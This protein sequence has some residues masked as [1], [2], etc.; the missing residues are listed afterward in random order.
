MGAL[1]LYAFLVFAL[2]SVTVYV[3]L[4]KLRD[5]SGEEARLHGNW[6]RYYGEG[7]PMEMGSAVAGSG[8]ARTE[9]F[10]QFLKGL[11]VNK[12]SAETE[13]LYFVLQFLM[14]MES[15]MTIMSALQKTQA[16]IEGAGYK[17]A[18]DLRKINFKLQGGV[19]FGEAIKVLEGSE[20]GKS[21]KEFFLVISQAQEI[22]VPVSDALKGA[23][24]EFEELRVI[25]AEERASRLSVLMAVPI[26]LGFLPSILL[27]VAMPAVS[28]LLEAFG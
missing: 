21:V 10:K 4:L 7:R 5:T 28:K 2:V 20:R 26:V 22:G 11:T 6:T 8:S 1:L 14:Y 15:G 12:V 13:T 19:P 17:L 16:S 23:I 9:R 3:I 24:K 27:L 25:R 18:D